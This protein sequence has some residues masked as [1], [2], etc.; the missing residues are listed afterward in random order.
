MFYLSA[1]HRA[2]GTEMQTITINV[3]KG[4]DAVSG[5]TDRPGIGPVLGMIE[6][7]RFNGEPRF[8]P[9]NLELEPLADPQLS[10]A[11]AIA[12][13]VKAYESTN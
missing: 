9:L 1:R 5:I 8:T 12:I 6:R 4:L 7:T 2:E 3:R 13:M 10:S 11:S